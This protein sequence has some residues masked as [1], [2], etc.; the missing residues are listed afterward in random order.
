MAEIPP[1][2]KN[3]PA[4]AASSSVGTWWEALVEALHAESRAARWGI[5][6]DQ[7]GRSLQRSVEK[8]FGAEFPASHQ[9]EEYTKGLHLEDLGLAC[10]C[11]EG[12]DAAWEGFVGAYRGYLRA[13]AAGILRCSGDAAEAVDLADSLF[14][15]LYGLSEGPRRDRSLFRYFHGRSSLKTWLRAVLAQRHIDAVRTRRRLEP[16][17]DG[18]AGQAARAPEGKPEVPDPHRTRYSNLFSRALEAALAA[19]PERDRSRLRAYYAEQLTLAEIGRRLGEHESSVSRN[20]ERIR[21]ELREA[22]IHLLRTGTPASDGDSAQKGLSDSEIA[23]SVEYAA[24]DAPIDV[25]KLF[26]KESPRR[27]DMARRKA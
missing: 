10:A 17:E 13:A 25:Q 24:E 3:H 5:T 1:N 19:L 4:G 21:A 27:P 8:R 20:L 18:E 23:L 9:V 6:P 11:A 2:S 22:V 16:L 12:C 7:F 14:A 26:P 15:E